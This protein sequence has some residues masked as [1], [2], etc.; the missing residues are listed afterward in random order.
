MALSGLKVKTLALGLLRA[1]SE[2]DQQKKVG[3]SEIA[4]PC[5][6]CLASRLAGEQQTPSKYWLGGKI[7]TAVHG[8]LE[9]AIEDNRDMPVFANAK[10]E[11]KIVL[12]DIKDYGTVSSKPDL[13]LVDDQHL[14]D[15]KTSTR[16]KSKKIQ[17]WIDGKQ[18]AETSYTMHKY[19]GQTQLYAWGLNQAGTPIDGISLV[20]INRD[21]TNETDVLEYTFEYDE[22]IALALWGRLENLWEEL[23]NGSHPQSYAGHEH[24]FNCSVNGLV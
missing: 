14:I 6:R 24:C 12:G 19:I 4:N 13:A 21:G 10:V 2:R 18:D 23:V 20:F 11:Q 8:L 15:W 5:T 3:A 17:A 22:S 16:A 9:D 7:G 1:E